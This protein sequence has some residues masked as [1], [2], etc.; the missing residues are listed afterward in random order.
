[1]SS[2]PGMPDDDTPWPINCRKAT[3]YYIYRV[4]RPHQRPIHNELICDELVRTSNIENAPPYTVEFKLNPSPD[5]G[6]PHA[7]Y[8]SEL[9]IRIGFRGK[10][11]EFEAGGGEISIEFEKFVF[12]RPVSNRQSD[13]WDTYWH[14]DYINLDI[15]DRSR[16]GFRISDFLFSWISWRF[17][18]SI[19]CLWEV[20]RFF[21][22]PHWVNQTLVPG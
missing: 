12:C 10:F 7:H 20:R 18:C 5:V 17:W 6:L 3:S 22:T 8:K 9:Q 2:K 13:V 16:F 11:V 1:M 19:A 15:S 14:I 4:R 21:S